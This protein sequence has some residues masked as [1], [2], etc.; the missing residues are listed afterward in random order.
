MKFQL[1][2]LRTALC[3]MM[4][5][6]VCAGGVSAALPHISASAAP[7]STCRVATRRLASVG[8]LLFA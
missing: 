8:M 1:R 3:V 4:G 5:I 6:A 2:T 7:D